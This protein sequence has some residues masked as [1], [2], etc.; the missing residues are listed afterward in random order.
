MTGAPIYIAVD[1]LGGNKK[2]VAIRLPKEL[3]IQ[4]LIALKVP[5]MPTRLHVSSSPANPGL[6]LSG[7][8]GKKLHRVA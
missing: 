2:G 4:L 1:A 8:L 5:V 3:A 6:N 7:A